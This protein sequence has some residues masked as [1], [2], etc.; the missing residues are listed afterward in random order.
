[1]NA[2]VQDIYGPPEEVLRVDEVCDLDGVPQAVAQIETAHTRGKI[3]V[4]I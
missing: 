4:A 2:V 3:A 1:M